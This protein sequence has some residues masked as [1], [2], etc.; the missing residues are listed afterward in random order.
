MERL[1]WSALE[2]EEKDRSTDWF[3]ALGIIVVTSSMAAIIFENYFFAVLLILGGVLLG[4]F[5]VK[6]P[7][8][9]SYELNNQ[10]LQIRTELFPYENIQSFW[11][12]LDRN[13]EIEQ[14]STL[15]IKSERFFAPIISIPIDHNRAEDIRSIFISKNIPK[16]EMRDHLS[17][18][19]MESLGF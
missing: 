3:W 13:E 7:A 19:I 8:M 4:I 5:A 6:K 15:F 17:T 1:E 2:Y 18:K 11:V 14:K 10:G 9:I 16:E 12:Q